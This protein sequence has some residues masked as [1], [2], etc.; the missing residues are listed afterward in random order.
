[1]TL[2]AL[3]KKLRTLQENDPQSPAAEHGTAAVAPGILGT[4]CLG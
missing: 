4:V 3:P 1:M 2:R